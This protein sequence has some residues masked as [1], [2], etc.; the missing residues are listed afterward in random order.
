M[1]PTIARRLGA[2]V[3]RS[4]KLH[5]ALR[6]STTAVIRQ[7]V[8]SDHYKEHLG[9]LTLLQAEDL[10][11][12]KPVKIKV[13]EY[14][15]VLSKG[16]DFL[17]TLP[18]ALEPLT[19]L[20]DTAH[21][22]V[23][24]AIAITEAQASL[25]KL[26]DATLPNLLEHVKDLELEP[27]PEPGSGEEEIEFLQRARGMNEAERKD[28]LDSLNLEMRAAIS[29]VTESLRLTP[30]S[31][32]T[33]GSGSDAESAVVFER[34]ENPFA[35]VA[36]KAAASTDTGTRK[37]EER[38]KFGMSTD[39]QF[40]SVIADAAPRKEAFKLK[41][42]VG[43]NFGL[44]QNSGEITDDQFAGVV[45]DAAPRKE[46]L[47][48]KVVGTNFGLGQNS[49]EITTRKP[50]VVAKP[51]PAEPSDFPHRSEEGDTPRP[52]A[53]WPRDFSHR[54]EEGDT[55]RPQAVRPRVFSHRSEEGDKPRSNATVRDLM[56]LQAQLEA[57][58][59]K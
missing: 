36:A 20:R 27:F 45:A 57:S 59:R 44:G 8:P 28:L 1:S 13:S 54:S 29:Q 15:A 42:V 11:R 47:K 34:K 32:E 9:R 25:R 43:R 24:R 3:N 31:Y 48:K 2:C 5:H 41:K 49:G 7:K 38:P 55:P 23:E 26:K 10:R 51:K 12:L 17:T 56:S 22:N 18:A 33:S 40:A 39:D 21:T 35:K 46:A 16:L 53:V 50:D 37:V 30:S 52:Q 14:D 6:M 58:F 19:K 4:T